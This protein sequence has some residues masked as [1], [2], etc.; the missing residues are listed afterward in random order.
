MFV[1]GSIIAPFS[2]YMF[3]LVSDVYHVSSHNSTEHAV[4]EH[5]HYESSALLNN[6]SV[7]HLSC[8]Y[9][10]LFATFSATSP[11]SLKVAPVHAPRVVLRE[12]TTTRLSSK[13]L[14]TFHLRGPPRLT[15]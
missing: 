15:S 1:M 5:A 2:H 11:T 13:K 10:S 4:H 7:Q 8:D 3:M 14:L 9:W 6:E 12:D